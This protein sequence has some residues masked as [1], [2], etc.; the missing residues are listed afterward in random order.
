M[1]PKRRFLVKRHATCW[2]EWYIEAD[3]PEEALATWH[4]GELAGEDYTEQP[5]KTEVTELVP[6]QADLFSQSG[7]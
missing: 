1:T 7:S 6:E 4:L 2:Q 3:T 5:D